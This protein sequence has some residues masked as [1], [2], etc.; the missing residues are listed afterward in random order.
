VGVGVGVG[1][2]G[3]GIPPKILSVEV[4]VFFLLLL[5]LGGAVAYSS[6]CTCLT[7]CVNLQHAMIIRVC[8]RIVFSWA[9]NT[10]YP[11]ICDTT[12][13]VTLKLSQNASRSLSEGSKFNEPQTPIRRLWAIYVCRTHAHHHSPPPRSK[14]R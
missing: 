6:E 3:G 2:G 4:V 8:T 11:K 1:G 14:P 7:G 9:T 13:T 12:S 10:D 5:E